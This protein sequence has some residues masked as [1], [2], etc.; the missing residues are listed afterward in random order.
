MNNYTPASHAEQG[1]VDPKSRICLDVL[2]DPTIVVGGGICGA[3]CALALADLNIK[4]V[5]IDQ[6]SRHELVQGMGINLQKEAIHALNQ[7]GIS[8]ESLL[9]VGVAIQKQSYYCPDGRHIVSL[10]KTNKTRGDENTPGQIAIHRGKLLQI[11]LD[12]IDVNANIEL[13]YQHKFLNIQS[14]GPEKVAI[15]AQEKQSSSSILLYGSV[16]LGTDGINSNVRG[17]LFPR[18]K[19]KN[20]FLTFHGITHYRGVAKKFPVFL[21]G[22]TMIL[23][24]GL[25]AKMVI[26]PIEAATKNGKQDVNW[27]ACIREGRV[28]GKSTSISNRNHV[29]EFLSSHGLHLDFLNLPSLVKSTS[30]ITAWPMVDLEPLDRWTEGRIA[31]AGDAAHAMLPVGSGGAMAALLD[32]IA[33]RDSFLKSGPVRAPHVLRLFQSIRYESASFQ[34]KKCRMQPAETIVEEIL[35]QISKSSEV[36]LEYAERIRCEMKK[37]HNPSKTMQKEIEKNVLIVGAG[38]SGLATGKEFQEY[39]Y[40]PVIF[41][42]GSTFGGVFRDAYENL[43]L[44]SSSAFTAFS[45]YPPNL[46]ETPKMW[47]GPEYLSYLHSYAVHNKI[48]ENIQFNSKVIGIRRKNTEQG[49]VADC[50]IDKLWEVSVFDSVANKEKVFEG[51]ILV[52]C[53]GSNAIPSKPLFLGQQSFSGNII[54]TSE[55]GTYEMFN[56]KRVLSLGIG[57]SGSDVPYWIAKQPEVTLTIAARGLGWCVPRRRPL[58]TGLPTDLNTNRILW[59]LPRFWN[60]VLSKL[61]VS[62]RYCS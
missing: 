44:T 24:G 35:C 33:L 21:D 32:A 55:V 36:P 5:V 30:Q 17:M 46:D 4:S 27:I 40:H 38:A 42:S 28:S 47:S 37:L 58:K 18:C 53:T 6:R 14:R 43:E 10:D 50:G 15:I 3:A 41:E 8:T 9:Q 20:D 11:L 54:H 22:K 7:L 23:C 26:Y 16:V 13:L 31:L 34:Q 51:C 60:R 62:L 12:K 19:S 2:K 39:G 48:F 45:D 57:E 25:N 52:I 1:R 56:G 59:G 29:L 61:L 49:S